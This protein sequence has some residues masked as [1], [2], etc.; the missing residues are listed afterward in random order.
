MTNSPAIYGAA[1]AWASA[2]RLGHSVTVAERA[3]A[4]VLRDLP[5]DARTLEAAAGIED[6]AQAIVDAEAAR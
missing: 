6:L 4:G 3:Y 2:K 1:S 5:A